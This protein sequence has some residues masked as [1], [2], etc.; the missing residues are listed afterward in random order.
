[1]G[2]SWDRATCRPIFWL[3][4]CTPNSK[5]PGKSKPRAAPSGLRY[6]HELA[7]WAADCDIRRLPI[8]PAEC[9]QSYHMF[10]LLLPTLEDRQAL[11]QHLG[12]RGILAVFPP[13]TA[14]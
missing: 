2:G 8:I 14:T 5:P 13:C 1:M 12:E 11:I 3:H 6:N 10:Y 9:E 7:D 4:S